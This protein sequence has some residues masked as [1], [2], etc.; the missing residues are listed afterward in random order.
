MMNQS[1]FPLG[2]PQNRCQILADRGSLVLVTPYD[3]DLVAD[4][5]AQIPS[6]DRK[7]DGQRKAWLV[8][9][10][11]GKLLTDLVRRH[12]GETLQL[13]AISQD[14]GAQE[15]RLLEVRYLGQC[16][17]RGDGFS[18]FGFVANEW[19][20][21]FPEETLRKWFEAGPSMA[22]MPSA[23]LTLYGVL[24]IKQNASPEELKTA[25]RRAARTWHPDVNRDPDAPE[26]FKKINHAY[27][28][29]N[30]PKLRARYDAGLALEASMAKQ[31]DR[32]SF[33]QITAQGYRAPLSCG[34]ILC[35]GTE[36][37]GRFIVE[38][39][40]A[41]EDITLGNKT[42]VSSWPVGAK[43]PFEQWV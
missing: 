41:W 1:L 34:Y 25:F 10:R 9:P 29:L 19:R 12:F 13:P 4:L 38:R 36:R 5:K 16:K 35:E 15:V 31:K 14:T 42:L 27:Q 11:H 7:Y 21:I 8:D 22:E 43:R 37:L 2:T 30:D 24:G 3:P 28:V 26:Q 39:I 23:A 17:F 40:L 33:P 18:A 6:S 32:S 20:A